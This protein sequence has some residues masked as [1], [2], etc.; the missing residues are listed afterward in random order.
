MKPD[1]EADRQQH[2]P[3]RIRDFKSPIAPLGARLTF[4]PKLVNC[5]DGL[6]A[7]L[8]QAAHLD[9]DVVRDAFGGVHQ[10]EIVSHESTLLGLSAGHVSGSVSL[11]GAK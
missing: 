5:P 10:V 2:G 1:I 4:G 9:P 11:L 7:G 6:F 8:L 3:G